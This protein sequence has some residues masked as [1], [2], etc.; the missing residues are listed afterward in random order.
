MG[1]ILTLLGLVGTIIALVMAVKALIKKEKKAT[2]SLLLIL[3]SVVLIVIGGT[4]LDSD[5]SEKAEANK[6][7]KLPDTLEER[8]EFYAKD[9]FGEDNVDTSNFLEG[10][11]YVYIIG[12]ESWDA[13]SALY[14]MQSD[15]LDFLEKLQNEEKVTSAQIDITQTFTDSYGNEEEKTVFRTDFSRDTIDKINYE[16]MDPKR[17]SEIADEYWIHNALK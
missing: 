6:E 16:N 7:E 4:M 17:V 14:G 2:K 11:A 12:D 5:S 8:I 13:E 15:T 10:N 1:I 9:V 3:V